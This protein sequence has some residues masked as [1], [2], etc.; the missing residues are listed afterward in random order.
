M[1]SD[2]PLSG[3]NYQPPHRLIVKAR[4]LSG[5]KRGYCWQIVRDNDEHSVIRQSSESF[6]SMEEAYTIGAVMLKRSV[7][8]STGQTPSTGLRSRH[9]SPILDI[10]TTGTAAPQPLVL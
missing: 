2:N 4:S 6:R 9:R 3:T 5:A 1:T 10:P 7:T 8:R